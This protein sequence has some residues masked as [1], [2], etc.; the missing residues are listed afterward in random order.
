MRIFL[1]KNK[2]LQLKIFVEMIVSADEF[3][4][5][6]MQY[7]KISSQEQAASS[8]NHCCSDDVSSK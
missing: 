4:N 3:V 1:L 2:Q 8:E 6:I 7:E 5:N